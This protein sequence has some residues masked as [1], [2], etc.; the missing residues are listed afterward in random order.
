[1]LPCAM[2]HDSVIGPVTWV[3]TSFV[4]ATTTVSDAAAPCVIA[5]HVAGDSWTRAGLEPAK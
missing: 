1:M 2:F 4:T 3:P 5:V